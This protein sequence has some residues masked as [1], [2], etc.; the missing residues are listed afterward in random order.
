MDWYAVR[1]VFRGTK[2]PTFYEERVTLW[3]A[4][5]FEDAIER[6]EAEAGEYTDVLSLR[7]LGLA[8]AYKLADE[9]GEGAE[10]F[11]LHR[12]SD[13]DADAYLTAFFDTGTERQR[14]QPSDRVA[15]DS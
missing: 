15:P 14:L 8:Q 5:S 13:L 11:S 10:V 9:P 4:G 12:E 3:R 1:C 2:E 6:A 7:Y